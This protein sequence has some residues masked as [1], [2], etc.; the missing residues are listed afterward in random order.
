MCIKLITWEINYTW[1]QCQV[2]R[3]LE[4]LLSSLVCSNISHRLKLL[5]SCNTL[6]RR[7]YC[8][9][10][11][12][13]QPV[14]RWTNESLLHCTT[15]GCNSPWLANISSNN[16]RPSLWVLSKLGHRMPMEGTA[17][18]SSSCFFYSHPSL[19]YFLP[20]P[21]VA[22]FPYEKTLCN[23]DHETVYCSK[24]P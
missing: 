1:R 7:M 18:Y 2:R 4:R 5:W 8:C 11:F 16:R 14:G 13:F 3:N 12:Y 15:M 22:L 20:V 19:D 23:T 10:W 9:L 21:L 24:T 17:G 6:H